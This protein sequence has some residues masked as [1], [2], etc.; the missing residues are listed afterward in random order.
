VLD[1]AASAW[2][3]PS[4]RIDHS[5]GL[6]RLCRLAVRPSFSDDLTAPIALR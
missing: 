6:T 4:G 2:R 5:E 3:C 1:S